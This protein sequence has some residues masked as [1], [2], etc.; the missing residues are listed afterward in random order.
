MADEKKFNFY[1]GKSTA[2]PRF[3]YRRLAAALQGN[4]RARGPVIDAAINEILTGKDPDLRKFKFF[5]PAFLKQKLSPDE[6]AHLEQ[7][8]AKR[9][10][11]ASQLKM[12][13]PH[14]GDEFSVDRDFLESVFEMHEGPALRHGDGFFTI[15]SCFARNVAQHLAVNGHRAKTFGLAEDLNSPMSNAFLLQMMERTADEQRGILKHWIETI[16]P[17]LADAEKDALIAQKHR[18]IAELQSN[19]E[20]ADCVILTLGNVVDFFRDDGSHG[21]PLM[22]N[23]FP[24]FIAMPGSEDINVRSASAANLK[25]KGAVLR[26]ATYS[27]TL[28]AIR[29]CIRGIRSVT[30]ATLVVTISP[31]PIDSVIGLVTQHLKSAIEVDCVSKSRIRSAFDEVYSAERRTDPAI[32][33]F[34]SFEI[35]RWIA[36]LMPIPAFGLDDAASRHVSSPILNGIC[37]LFAQT[38]ISFTD[39]PQAQPADAGVQSLA[40]E[41]NV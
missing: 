37:S 33:Y 6:L 3:V 5:A 25:G 1:G 41:R 10:E 19:L 21:K 40:L 9:R 20:E 14:V 27:E 16:F 26:L 39:N 17:D 7:Q 31:V 34:P 24:K 30:N 11:R 36:P 2:L 13:F 4:G 18:E 29:T 35:V 15:G 32:F 38:F 12:V 28:E 23:I 8:T 22:E